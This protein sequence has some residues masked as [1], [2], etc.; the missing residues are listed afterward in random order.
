MKRLAIIAAVLATYLFCAQASAQSDTQ[1][2]QVTVNS[3]LTITAPADPAA[4]IEANANAD[5]AFAAQ[6]WQIT[7]NDQSGGTATFAVSM[8]FV[9]TTNAAFRADV[10]IV[11]VG[12]RAA[13]F[14][15]RSDNCRPSP[16][17]SAPLVLTDT[18]A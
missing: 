3:N 6:T 5:T 16:F 7:C 18:L 4:I 14:F 13:S 15:P 17:L 1:T 8:V 9:H 12:R 10:P 2:F 11:L